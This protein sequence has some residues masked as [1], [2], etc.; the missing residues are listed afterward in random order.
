[1]SNRA[2]REASGG[3]L[4]QEFL[5]AVPGKRVKRPSGEF[6]GQVMFQAVF[7]GGRRGTFPLADTS[8]STVLMIP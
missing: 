2:E 8:S 3:L 1:V 6:T 5:E 4:I 7:I